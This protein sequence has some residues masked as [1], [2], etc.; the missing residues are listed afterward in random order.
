MCVL[1]NTDV[2][3]FAE[4]AERCFQL[5]RKIVPVLFLAIKVKDDPSSVVFAFYDS[6][7]PPEHW[8]YSLVL[9]SFFISK[10]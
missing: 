7:L 10:H 1:L 4:I 8:I 6:A 5:S 2:L 3:K 9:L